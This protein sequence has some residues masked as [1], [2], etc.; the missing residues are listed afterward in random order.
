MEQKSLR[1]SIRKKLK[2]GPAKR[3]RREGKIPAVV[4]GHSQPMAIAVEAREFNQ[5]FASIQSNVLYDIDIEGEH[6]DVLVKEVQKDIIT[7]TIKHIDFFEIERGKTLRTTVP[8]QIEGSAAGVKE[9]GLLEEH[10]HSLEI[11]CMPKDIPTF[12]PLDVSS[13]NI[14][15]SLH[16]S[17]L[18]APEGVKILSSLEVAIVGVTVVKSVETEEA[19]EEEDLVAEEET[20]EE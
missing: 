16:V 13:L 7:D 10:L 20:E 5:N 12:I 19:V 4:Y 3:L 8:I 14:G 15:D 1:V 18:K 2:K 6:R 9:G 17:D 11:E